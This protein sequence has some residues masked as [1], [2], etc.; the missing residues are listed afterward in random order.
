MRV[1]KAPRGTRAIE[2]EK[3]NMKSTVQKPPMKREL[4]PKRKKAGVT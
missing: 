4:G 3:E 2:G 1:Y